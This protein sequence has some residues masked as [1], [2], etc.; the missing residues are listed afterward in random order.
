MRYTLSVRGG[1]QHTG[2]NPH[3]F[4]TTEL[5]GEERPGG[6]TI[7]GKSDKKRQKDKGP[8]FRHRGQALGGG[9]RAA[10]NNGRSAL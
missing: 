4:G 6:H 9:S 10:L 2:S 8:I 7:K 1:Q 3:T 5:I